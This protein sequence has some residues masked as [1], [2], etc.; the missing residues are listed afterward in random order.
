M[1][2]QSHDNSFPPRTWNARRLLR[3]APV[4]LHALPSLRTGP[5]TKFVVFAQGKTGS[6]LLVDLLN[7]SPDVHCDD[8]ILYHPV[9]LPRTYVLAHSRRANKP[10]YGFKVKVYQLEREQRRDAH[11]FLHDL[12][13]RDWKIIY[14]RRN[15]LLRQIL[16]N[17]IRQQRGT[18]YYQPGHEVLRI[19]RLTVDAA[20]L[21]ARLKY[22]QEQLQHEERALDG[23]P[24][25]CV[26]YED[27]LIG[28]ENHQRTLDRLFDHLGA[29][30]TV[31]KTKL[32]RINTLPLSE[33]IANYD[34]VARHLSRAG[35]GSFLEAR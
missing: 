24:H 34:E 13:A 17:K 8:E 11:R 16:S 4:Y 18:P 35:F 19:E 32:G 9:P 33:L 7:S 20:D 21:I 12:H 6:T 5:K 10:I 28:A 29:Q 26:T 22:R 15:N 31:V 30:R 23:L 2:L 3:Q 25:L 27:D 14:L 1:P